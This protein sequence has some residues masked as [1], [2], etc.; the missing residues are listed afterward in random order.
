V[1]DVGSTRVEAPDV[2]AVVGDAAGA[3]TGPPLRIC[4]LW[5]RLSGYLS[6]SL[7][8]L[9]DAGADVLVV[10]EAA[11]ADAPFDDGELTAGFRAVAWQGAPDERELMSLLDEFAPDGLVV[12]SWHIGAYRRAS[13][14]L[15][16]RT[17]RIVT[18]HNQWTATP[19][20]LAARAAARALLH[21][22]YDVAFV[23]DERQAIFA[24]KLGFPAERMLWGVNTCDQP[25]FARVAAERGDRL[26]PPAF[27]F[28]GRLVEDKA[29]DVLAEAYGR[30][31]SAVADPWP[32]RIAGVGPMSG[33]LERIDGVEMLGFVQ[34]AEL[35]GVFASAG[36]LVLPSRIEPWGVVVH[37]ATSAG[38]PVVCT[39]ACGAATRLVLDG[40]N[41]AV[42]SPG[43]ASGLA[44]A[45]ARI[46]GASAEERRAMGTGSELL[47]R[48][49]TPQRWA[50]V[51]L[52]RVRAA[53][54]RQPGPPAGSSSR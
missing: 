7:R 30:Y 12:N 4:V 20:Q 5:S 52:S 39:R 49:F 46:S 26:P 10:H 19:K 34:P 47:S 13:R 33:L 53:A 2:G 32:L 25:L 23:C 37:E 40:Y 28:V 16:G 14:R 45:L 54:T 21:P 36:C 35:P 22:T 43:D 44:H 3:G 9:A 15:R 11:G 50:Q 42:V 8:A 1:T 51:L 41:G 17:L 38:L 24:E 29:V 18:V 27:L 6:A 31:R 48:Q